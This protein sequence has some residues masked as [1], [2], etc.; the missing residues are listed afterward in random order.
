MK[1]TTLTVKQTTEEYDP[2]ALDSAVKLAQGKITQL[3]LADFAN[4]SLNLELGPT[5]IEISMNDVA[6]SE[7]D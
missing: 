7:S 2:Q 1:T 3:K 4:A 5:R 6:S